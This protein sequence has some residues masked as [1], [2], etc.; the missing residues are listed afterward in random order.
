MVMIGAGF[1]AKVRE[2]NQATANE[3]LLVFVLI[4]PN[5]IFYVWFLAQFRH[6]FL[7]YFGK[8]F[9]FWFK[10]FSCGL[11]TPSKYALKHNVKDQQ[12]TSKNGKK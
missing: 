7:L 4:I 5:I 11:T 10:V 12:V 8:D 1:Y 3:V 6:E 9:P 2:S